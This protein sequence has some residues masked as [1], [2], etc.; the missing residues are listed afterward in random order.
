MTAIEWNQAGQRT[1]EF[2]VDRGVFFPKIGIGV[3]WTGLISIDEASN[4]GDAA[5][6]YFDGIKY[7]DFIANE[8]YEASLQAFSAPSEFNVCDGIKEIAQGLSVTQQPR[9]MFDLSYRSRVGNDLEGEDHGYKIH[10]VWDATAA[11]SDQSHKTMNDAPD[12]EMR[13]WKI[14]T[15][16]PHWR[17]TVFKPTAH[18]VIDSRTTPPATL[19]T[20]EGYLYGT[21]TTA[22]RMPDQSEVVTLFG[23][24]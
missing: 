22:P 9:S 20:L 10:L 13:T 18:F 4:G 6:Y 3:P 24:V 21:P 17:E 5:S 15:V 11:S 12:P 23:G 1:F 19:T 16:P 8:T 7:L 2:G 14:L